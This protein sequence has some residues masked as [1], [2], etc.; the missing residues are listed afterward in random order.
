M[1][2]ITIDGNTLRVGSTYADTMFQELYGVGSAAYQ[3]WG[4]TTGEAGWMF[5]DSNQFP[6]LPSTKLEDSGVVA[7]TYG[8]N[9]AA[10]QLTIDAAG[11]ITAASEVTIA[12]EILDDLSDTL[13]TTPTTGQTIE[14]NGTQ[15]V[16]TGQTST[17]I[18][19]ATL[20]DDASYIFT[21]NWS[22]YTRI[23]ILLFDILPSVDSTINLQLSTNSGTSWLGGT[24]Y[25]YTGIIYSTVANYFNTS[26]GSNYDLTLLAIDNTTTYLN[27]KTTLTGHTSSDKVNLNTVGS[28]LYLDSTSLFSIL[29]GGYVNT[30]APVNGIK[31]YPASGT[32]TSGYIEIR[33]YK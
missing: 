26:G 22:D 2:Q 8:N 7:G 13:I 18:A 12:L 20:D 27:I 1:A 17:I 33:G 25:I 19:S 10:P 21:G 4:K 28:A 14:Y 31:I 24:E 3:V 5:V 15:W 30:I 29:T 16:N 23:E 9:E 32:L 11:F 6:E